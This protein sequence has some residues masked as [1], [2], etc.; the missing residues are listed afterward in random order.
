MR[1]PAKGLPLDHLHELVFEAHRRISSLVPLRVCQGIS[2]QF[3]L[4]I[5]KIADR[6][7]LQHASLP[8]A[9][10][11]LSLPDYFRSQVGKRRGIS[12]GQSP[13]SPRLG[14]FGRMDRWVLL[15]HR[16]SR[17]SFFSQFLSHA[18]QNIAQLDL[19]PILPQSG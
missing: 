16:L 10:H 8:N 6:G 9:F 5:E 17:F 3:F 19:R 2:L 13:R 4:L 1:E 18:L 12:S 14:G 7:H 11:D 15:R